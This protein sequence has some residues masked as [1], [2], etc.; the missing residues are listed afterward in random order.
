M[1]VGRRSNLD[2]LGR[3]GKKLSKGGI[4]VTALILS[5]T[6]AFMQVSFSGHGYW[7]HN[8]GQFG[9]SARTE[10]LWQN[11]SLKTKARAEA[12][13]LRAIRPVDLLVYPD[14]AAAGD[15]ILPQTGVMSC[16]NGFVVESV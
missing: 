9:K 10:P 13:R 15:I 4:P 16:I 7:Q 14:K 12:A 5:R 3:L 1:L 8:G 6:P 11:H 2:W